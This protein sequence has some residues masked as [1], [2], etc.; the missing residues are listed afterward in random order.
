[1]VRCGMRITAMSSQRLMVGV[2]ESRRAAG[3]YNFTF[4]LT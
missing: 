4:M 1:M 3:A 2:E